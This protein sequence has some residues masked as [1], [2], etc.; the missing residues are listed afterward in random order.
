MAAGTLTCR[1]ETAEVIDRCALITGHSTY[2]V[3]AGGRQRLLANA[4]TGRNRPKAAIYLYL[5]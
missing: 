3:E 1:S 5:N 4:A 2:A